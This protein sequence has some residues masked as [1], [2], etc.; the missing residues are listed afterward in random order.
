MAKLTDFVDIKTGEKFKK[1]LMVVQ[2]TV[3][4]DDVAESILE[5]MRFQYQM[6]S[7]TPVNDGPHSGRML[8][9]Y[10]YAGKGKTQ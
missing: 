4:V 9:L 7:I 6:I 5:H 8:L 2:D 3:P 10:S 1:P